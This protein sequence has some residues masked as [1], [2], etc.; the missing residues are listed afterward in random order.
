MFLDHS[1]KNYSEICMKLILNIGL[2]EEKEKESNNI[3]MNLFFC[4]Y[5]KFLG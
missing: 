4:L 3:G 1:K 2:K 5:K